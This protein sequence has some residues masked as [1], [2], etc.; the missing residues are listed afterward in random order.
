MTATTH[1]RTRI[2]FPE[3]ALLSLIIIAGLTVLL[4]ML[5]AS[6][7]RARA[8]LCRYNL[9]QLDLATRQHILNFRRL[10]DA[11]TWPTEL[12]P[13]LLESTTPERLKLGLRVFEMSRPRLLT[14]PS[15]PN[16][17]ERDPN[18]QTS[19]YVLV[20]DR[21]QNRPIDE[22][23]WNYRDRVAE[24]PADEVKPWYLGVELSLEDADDQMRTPSGPHDQGRFL[25]SK[26]DGTVDF[27]KPLR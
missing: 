8:N 7:E 16:A 27:A 6:R 15:H 21:N 17:T 4:P 24:P 10:P 26:G 18:K 9:R 3:I 19:L 5:P 12:L 1:S 14:C 13:E 20:I 2:T 23:K 25:Q 11:I 22:M